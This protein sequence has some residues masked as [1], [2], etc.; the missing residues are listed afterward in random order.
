MEQ[1]YNV[2]EK[3][4]KLVD[5]ILVIIIAC[6]TI[7]FAWKGYDQGHREGFIYIIAI[8]IYFFLGLLSLIRSIGLRFEDRK[9]TIFSIILGIFG[10]LYITIFPAISLTEKLGNLVHIKDVLNK[11]DRQ[12]INTQEFNNIKT[13]D[14]EY[15]IGTNVVIKDVQGDRILILNKNG[16]FV[17]KVLNAK[18]IGLLNNPENY[19]NKSVAITVDPSKTEPVNVSVRTV[20]SSESLILLQRNLTDK[21]YSDLKNNFK[22]RVGME[23]MPEITKTDLCWY[24]IENTAYS[25]YIDFETDLPVV[26]N[27]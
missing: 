19:I 24:G 12:E 16:Y 5:K 15:Y 9:W 18:D 14:F 1:Q 10:L 27:K 22:S 26:L 2:Q 11:K 17:L 21:Y 13:Q 4:M 7:Y 25:I 23:T 20:C 6:T 3:R 8:P